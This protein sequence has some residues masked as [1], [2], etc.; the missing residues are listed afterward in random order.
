MIIIKAIM[1]KNYKHKPT[2]PSKKNIVH[3]TMNGFSIFLIIIDLFNCK[4]NSNDLLSTYLFHKNYLNG[5]QKYF[6]VN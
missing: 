6:L 3:G 4:I 1:G 5:N 2:I